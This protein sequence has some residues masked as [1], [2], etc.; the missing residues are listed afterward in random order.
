[1]TKLIAEPNAAEAFSFLALPSAW[2]Y[3]RCVSAG[4]DA[5]PFGTFAFGERRIRPSRYTPSALI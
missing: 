4:A 5:P 2:S 1:M 3:N